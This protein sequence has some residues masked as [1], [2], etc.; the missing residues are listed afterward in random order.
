MGT[1]WDCGFDYPHGLAC[2]LGNVA[3]MCF[4]VVYVPQFILNFKRKSC[5][6]FSLDSTIIKLVG[7]SFLCFNSLFNGSGLP[8]FL[9]GS[10]NTAQH[11]LFLFQFSYYSSHK[12]SILISPIVLIPLVLA[13]LFPKSI[14]YTDLI[15]PIC[16]ILSHIPQLQQ[17]IKFHTTLGCSLVGQHL[18]LIG[19]ILGC[20]MCYLINEQSAKTWIIYFNS[21]FQALSMYLVAFW[22]HEMRLCDNSKRVRSDKENSDSEPLL[23]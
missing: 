17:C 7:S 15:K 10:L 19:G 3:S 5:N 8:V 6:G 13:K 9:Y 2:W 16:Q 11:L 18:N 21:C 23:S 12:K 4:F 1:K 22:Y 20:F 14:K